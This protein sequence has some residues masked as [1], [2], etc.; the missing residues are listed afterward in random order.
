MDRLSDLN[1]ADEQGAIELITPLIERAPD[2]A[3]RVAR[4][5]P[6]DNP[7]QLS[8]AIR[9]ELRNL[10]EVER[11]DLFR[12]H[13]ELAPDNPLAMTS[14]SQSEQGR[15]NLTAA[16]GEYRVRLSELNARYREKH[17]FPFITALVRHADIESV[18]REFEARLSRDRQMEI[19]Q[20]I[21]EIASV[22]AS[23][24]RA[25]FGAGE[26]RPP[27]LAAANT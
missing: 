6:F 13:P 25:S 20:A 4:H 23:R 2:I 21:D 15:L 24:V 26:A 17:G 1:S 10:S 5:R 14:E 27:D 12:A 19:E 3:R 22:S 8:E 11:I 9:S 18:M 16:E 7:E